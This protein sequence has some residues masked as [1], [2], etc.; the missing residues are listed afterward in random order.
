MKSF[1]CILVL[2]GTIAVASSGTKEGTPAVTLNVTR[3]STAGV[4]NVELVNSSAKP[5]KVWEEANSWG[6]AHWRV[7]VIRN[8]NLQT[9]Y[10]NPDR[11]FSMNVPRFKVIPAGAREEHKLDLNGGNWCGLDYCAS[12]H[13]R[14]FGGKNARLEARD[15]VIVVYDVPPADDVEARRLGVWHGVTSTLA[16]V[17][18]Q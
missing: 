7:L 18:G 3:L 5:V 11:R 14:G 10:E 8:G 13:E 1:F 17:S 9:F 6:A 12:F 16:I 4:V 2:I 15:T